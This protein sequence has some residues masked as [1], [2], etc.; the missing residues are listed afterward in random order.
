M[1]ALKEFIG[2]DGLTD[3]DVA[4][5]AADI[6][7]VGDIIHGFENPKSVPIGYKV[8]SQEASE[9]ILENPV[10]AVGIVLLARLDRLH[11]D[12]LESQKTT[13]LLLQDAIEGISRAWAK[14]PLGNDTQLTV[15][16]H[17]QALAALK[18]RWLNHH[19][20]HTEAEYIAAINEFE[21][22]LG[23]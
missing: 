5:A 18:E 10:L 6:L 23:L 3:D 22:L 21:K 17:E 15:M 2:L 8:S 20:L 19:P 11:Y 16:S 9:A 14:L 4:S 13:H 7:C 12:Y 1:D